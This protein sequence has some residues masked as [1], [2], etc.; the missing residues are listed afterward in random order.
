MSHKLCL[1]YP[2]LQSLSLH[3]LRKKKKTYSTC[4]LAT[5][6]NIDSTIPVTQLVVY[7]A[8]VE[9]RAC[10]MGHLKTW[11]GHSTSLQ[12]CSHQTLC[13]ENTV[14]LLRVNCCSIK[15]RKQLGIID[16]IHAF[17]SWKTSTGPF[18]DAPNSPE[19]VLHEKFRINKYMCRKS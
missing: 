19:K 4:S 5:W 13:N 9:K 15:I 7:V 8:I 2:K 10:S 18:R 14:C 12:L 16:N 1:T 6:D 17:A 11:A 3:I